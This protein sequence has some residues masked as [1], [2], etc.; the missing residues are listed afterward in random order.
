MCLVSFQQHT[1]FLY[2]NPIGFGLYDCLIKHVN[3]NK[4]CLNT[5]IHRI[6]NIMW[7]QHCSEHWQIEISGYR[8]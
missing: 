4:A 2:F 7:T 5:E 6:E 1:A 8:Y 3:N